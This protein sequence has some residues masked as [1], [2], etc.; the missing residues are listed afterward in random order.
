MNEAL[1]SIL[2]VSSYFMKVPNIVSSNNLYSA[3]P[4]FAYHHGL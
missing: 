2:P 4:K 1:G 3:T